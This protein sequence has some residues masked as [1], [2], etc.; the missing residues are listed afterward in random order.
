MPFASLLVYTFDKLTYY[1]GDSVWVN[2]L[3]DDIN[4][5]IKDGKIRQANLWTFL[6]EE[7]MLSYIEE[8]KAY[9]GNNPSVEF[10]N[11]TTLNEKVV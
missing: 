5:G 10:V 1:Y 7:D 4:K 2:K 3:Y 9:H 6:Y 11:M 8:K